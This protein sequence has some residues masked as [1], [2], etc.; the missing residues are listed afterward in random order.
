[1]VDVAKYLTSYRIG[2]ALRVAISDFVDQPGL[3]N[4]TAEALAQFRACGCFPL[5]SLALR[6]PTCIRAT[7][8][9]IASLQL[10][11]EQDRK[12][13]T[14]RSAPRTRRT[15][16]SIQWFGESVAAR[17]TKYVGHG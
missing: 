6:H 13:T 7:N 4:E 3:L 14:K 10:V 11:F 16:T 15:R 5:E 8:N 17:A 1:M 2:N 9:E 12:I